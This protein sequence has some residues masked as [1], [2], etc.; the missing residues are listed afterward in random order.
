MRESLSPTYELRSPFIRAFNNRPCRYYFRLIR[1]DM[2]A[3]ISAGSPPPIFHPFPPTFRPFLS[4]FNRPSASGERTR[5]V[6]EKSYRTQRTMRLHFS[7]FFF[8]F[9]LLTIILVLMRVIGSDPIGK[10]CSK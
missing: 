5:G 6:G 2:T 8:R 10:F 9:F 4:G 1:P 7:V 3:I